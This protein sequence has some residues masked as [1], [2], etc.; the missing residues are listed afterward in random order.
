MQ[1][2]F[3]FLIILLLSLVI[4][5]GCYLWY[6]KYKIF[7]IINFIIATGLLYVCYLNYMNNPNTFY[8]GL[9]LTGLYFTVFGINMIYY[10]YKNK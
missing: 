8:Y 1:D 9:M 3:Y 6:S 4:Y 5:Y 2:K 10:T 7:T